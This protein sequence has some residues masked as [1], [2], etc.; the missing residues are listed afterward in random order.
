MP[1]Y[2]SRGKQ[3]SRQGQRINVAHNYKG[4][5]RDQ[6]GHRLFSVQGRGSIASRD[7]NGNRVYIDGIERF[8]GTAKACIEFCKSHHG[9]FVIVTLVAV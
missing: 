4:Y 6:Y 8:K 5:A 7:L 9:Q 1:I 2:K 3:D